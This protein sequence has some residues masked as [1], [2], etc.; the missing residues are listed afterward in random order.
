MRGDN[1]LKYGSIKDNIIG[2]E[3]VT[4]DGHITSLSKMKK[5]NTGYDLKSIICNSEGTLGL[6]TKVLL[7]IYPKPQ[8]NFTFIV[9]IKI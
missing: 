9:L 5:N 2:L 8:N 3:I 7:K 1:A 6:I 4:G